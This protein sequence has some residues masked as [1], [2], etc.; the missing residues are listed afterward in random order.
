MVANMIG[1]TKNARVVNVPLELDTEA[2][3]GIYDGERLC[4]LVVLNMQAFNQTTSGSRP[5]RK[6]DFRVPT[7]YHAA[8]AERLIAP[9]S[10]AVDRVTFAGISYD[11]GLRAGKPVVVDPTEEIVTIQDGV[12]GVDVPDSSAVLLTLL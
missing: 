2:A 7:D 6:Y 10:D 3:Y 8:K 1:H 12:L 5:S 9:G 11:Y 4:K